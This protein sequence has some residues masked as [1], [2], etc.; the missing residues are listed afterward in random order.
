MTTEDNMRSL[1]SRESGEKHGQGRGGTYDWVKSV[2]WRAAVT[3]TVFRIRKRL[4]FR[5]P[6]ELK[7]KPRWAKH[8]VVV[9]LGGSSDL[10]VFFQIFIFEEYACMRDIPSPGLIVDLGANVGYASAYFLN[11]FPNARIV[12]VEPDPSNFEQCRSNLAPY[13]DRAQVVLGAAWS[14]RSRLVLSRGTFGDGL[15]WAIQ[16]HESEG[17]ED[18]ATVDAWDVPSLMQLAGGDSIDLLKVDI[19]G[20]ETEIFDSGSLSWL[21]KIR[22]ICIELHGPDC[23]KVFFDALQDFDYDLARS[24][25]LT[26]TRNLRRKAA[27]H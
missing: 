7:I 1:N 25:E 19:E 4:G 22:N 9:R 20:S 23:E 17:K 26:I 3:W 14:K 24:G 11:Y 6:A 18:M 8:P 21:P 15:D 5:Q 27:Q 16:V 12:S 13:G 2:G 10:S